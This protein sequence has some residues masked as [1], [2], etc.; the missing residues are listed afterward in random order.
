MPNLTWMLKWAAA[1]AALWFVVSHFFPGA[2]GVITV[3]F[4]IV[5]A[6]HILFFLCDF[7]LMRSHRKNYP[8]W[9]VEAIE[10]M[11]EQFYEHYFSVKADASKARWRMEKE[12]LKAELE[13]K[14]HEFNCLLYWY[15]K[16]EGWN[17]KWS[18]GQVAMA[19]EYERNRFRILGI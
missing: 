8:R 1:G 2:I 18:R 15:E 4:Y 16:R 7:L 17:V 10:E 5:A 12:R 19:L 13:I 14:I 9:Y 6:G 3:F 11:V